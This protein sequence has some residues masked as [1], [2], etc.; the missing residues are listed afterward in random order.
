MTSRAR[1]TPGGPASGA[2]RDDKNDAAQEHARRQ[3]GRGPWN[4]SFTGSEALTYRGQV[5]Q[6]R[7]VR[8]A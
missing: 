3:F 5:R 4:D 7:Q 1:D 2:A 8:Q 6:V